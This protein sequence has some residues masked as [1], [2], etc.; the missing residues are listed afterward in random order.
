MC[1]GTVQ[2]STYVRTCILAAYCKIKCSEASLICHMQL[3]MSVLG[4]NSR[5]GRLIRFEHS[6]YCKSFMNTIGWMSGL[7][8][9]RFGG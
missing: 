2:Y 1:C 6:T 8:D 4:W 3:G 9:E 7:V 5:V